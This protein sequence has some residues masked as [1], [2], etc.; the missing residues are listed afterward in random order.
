MQVSF[1]VT[2]PLWS[3]Q[4]ENNDMFIDINTS[5][6]IVI[7]TADDLSGICFLSFLKYRR[8]VPW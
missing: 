4:V 8:V 1:Y 2:C 3:F 5:V 7:R 6:I